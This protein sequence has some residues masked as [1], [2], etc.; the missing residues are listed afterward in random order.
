[1][2]ITTATVLPT[3]DHRAAVELSLPPGAT[4]VAIV[5]TGHGHPS[6]GLLLYTCGHSEHRMEGDA[7][8]ASQLISS[9]AVRVA[10]AHFNT[11]CPVCMRQH[12]S[13][14]HKCGCADHVELRSLAQRQDALRVRLVAQAEEQKK[15]EAAARTEAAARRSNGGSP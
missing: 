9:Q 10:P 5:L 1:M 12:A 6:V 14:A 11:D 4:S 8:E 13:E 2:T 15:A 3:S 7:H